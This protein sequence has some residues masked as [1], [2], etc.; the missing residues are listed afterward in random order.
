VNVLTGDLVGVEI[1]RTLVGS[2]GLVAAVPLTTALAAFVVS[3]GRGPRSAID[4]TEQLRELHRAPSVPA[5]AMSVVPLLERALAEQD[6]VAGWAEPPLR[7]WAGGV[8]EGK[9]RP[10]PAAL[11]HRCRLSV[12][13]RGVDF[14]GRGHLM[15]VKA[16]AKHSTRNSPT[17]MPNPDVAASRRTTWTG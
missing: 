15:Y 17:A 7:A 2:I 11:A 12:V 3:T 10:A 5:I 16:M 1:V 13:N 4:E 6:L 8:V 9:E 14:F